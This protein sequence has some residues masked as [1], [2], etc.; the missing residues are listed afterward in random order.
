MS[1][2]VAIVVPVTQREHLTAEEQVSL[3]HLLQYLAPYPKYFVAP[4]SG[5]T[6]HPDFSVKRFSNKFFGSAL[7]H[8][9]L[10]LSREF[11]AAFSE[12]EYILDYHLDSLVFSDRLEQWCATGVDYIGAPWIKS[13]HSPWVDTPRVGNGGFSLRKI[14]SFLN[15]FDSTV[16]SEIPRDYWAKYYG[17]LPLHQRA[18]N[19]PKKYLKQLSCFNNVSWELKHRRAA[20]DGTMP[21]EELFWSDRAIHYYPGFKVASFDEGLSF[22]FEVEPRKCFEMN[23]FKL[24][25]GCHAWARYDREFWE[26]YLL[27]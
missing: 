26:P 8:S 11:Y 23:G 10:M 18:L 21:G 19:L 14:R 25:F 5:G 24:P 7:A 2:Q 22:A 4:E 16:Q 1:K 9:N 17:D 15:V 6:E 13:E 20:M 3:R 27:R 12:Y